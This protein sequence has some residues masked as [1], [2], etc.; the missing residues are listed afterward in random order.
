MK[1]LLTEKQV[2]TLLEVSIKTLQGWRLKG[3]GPPYVKM[4]R[5]IRYAESDLE[6]YVIEKRRTSTSDGGRTLVYSPPPGITVRI[7]PAHERRLDRPR[8]A[9]CPPPITPRPV[10]GAPTGR[11]HC[12]PLEWVRIRYRLPNQRVTESTRRRAR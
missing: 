8:A 2:A 11:R 3:G 10:P 9:A 1:K 7:V 5:L 12:V 4:G 6:A